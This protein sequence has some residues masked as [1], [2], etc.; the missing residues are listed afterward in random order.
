MRLISISVTLFGLLF[1]LLFGTAQATTVLYQDFN[2]LIDTSQHVLTGVV[3]QMDANQAANGDIYTTLIFAMRRVLRPRV[4]HPSP[5]RSACALRAA[6]LRNWTNNSARSANKPYSP[7]VHQS[8]V[9]ET[10]SGL[11]QP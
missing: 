9:W 4:Q 10:A 7:T 1:G 11:C 2:Q 5:R 3:T 8:S 6:P